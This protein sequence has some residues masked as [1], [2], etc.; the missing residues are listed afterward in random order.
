MEVD[1]V[2]SKCDDVL[3]A[4]YHLE[5]IRKKAGTYTNEGD[6]REKRQQRGLGIVDNIKKSHDDK[7]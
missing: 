6:K 1:I 3:E 4:V 5:Y 7:M 2:D